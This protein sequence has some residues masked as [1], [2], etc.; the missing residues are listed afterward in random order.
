MSALKT[1]PFEHFGD[2]SLRFTN[3]YCA[4]PEFLNPADNCEEIINEGYF[5]EYF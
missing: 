1:G 3:N 2:E 4:S 5:M